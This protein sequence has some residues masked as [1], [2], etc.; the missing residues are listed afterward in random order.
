MQDDRSSGQ[1]A[2]QARPAPSL[3]CLARALFAA[4][5]G[6][7]AVLYGGD[8]QGVQTLHAMARSRLT[9]PGLA[10]V[11]GSVLGTAYLTLNSA[12]I[13]AH[14]AELWPGQLLKVPWPTLPLALL[15]LSVGWS[16]VL[17]GAAMVSLGAYLFAFI[18]IAY[19]SI[20]P[21]FELAGTLWFA[22][23]P[24]WGLVLGAW[25]ASSRPGRWG[26][27]LFLLLLSLAIALLIYPSLGLK[28]VFPP[29]EGQLALA[30]A[31]FVL[32][33]NP[34]ALRWRRFRPGVAFA[35]SL[36]V[37]VAFYGLAIARS[38]PVAVLQNTFLT[39]N[40]LLTI[41]GLLWLWMG[42]GLFSGAQDLAGWIGATVQALVPRRLLIGFVFSAWA[43]WSVVAYL[44]SHVPPLFVIEGLVRLGLGEQLLTAWRAAQEALVSR[45]AAEYDLYVTLAIAALAL[46]LWVGRAL[47]T[48]RLMRLFGLSLAAYFI[49]SG[50]WA[51]F[52]ESATEVEMPSAGLLPLIL[53]VGGM[54]WELVKL[55]PD[56]V[57]GQKTRAL[58]FAGLLALFGG[59]ALLEITSQHAGLGQTVIVS[60]YMGALYLGLPYLLYS[61][62]YAARPD[63]P[64]SGGYLLLLFALGALS[65]FPSL[66]GGHIFYAP[67]IWLLIL[68][69]TAWRAGRWERLRDSLVYPVTAALGFVT[70]YTNPML[71]SL[72]T[73]YAVLVLVPIPALRAFTDHL[74]RLEDGLV[75]SYV[76]PTR[77]R[78]WWILLAAAGAAAVLGVFMGWARRVQGWRRALVLAAG[79]AAS[80]GFLAVCEFV[81]GIG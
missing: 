63:R 37:F 51:L 21:G 33:A 77:A 31:C 4:L 24:I 43:L 49:I 64:V 78:W 54:V 23:V 25:A 35:V 53:F 19:Y 32:V 29:V 48:E 57:S 66:F 72:R 28:A 58:F 38:T 52:L 80:L 12:A 71:F 5:K 56:I 3:S 15:L 13:P 65:A 36:V 73:F 2:S 68:L 16:Y 60:T 20:M 79:L 55:G 61:Y 70:L 7:A 14:A 59:F 40:E 41:V 17:A 27:L 18:Y 22:L 67:L 46:V 50:L 8:W 34:L 81:V 9:L 10:L 1:R 11:A 6:Y 75:N 30:A 44:V 26:R 39:L 76:P 62:L 69:A 45:A 74:M 42:L 47:S